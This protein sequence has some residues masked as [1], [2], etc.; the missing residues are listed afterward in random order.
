M[1]PL[2]LT[3]F[4]ADPTVGQ[5][6]VES[7]EP[8]T[9]EQAAPTVTYEL[10]SDSWLAV[11]VQYDRSSL[12]GGHDHVVTP[13][14]IKGTVTWN[15]DDPSVCKV[16]I[17]FAVDALQVDPPGAR[18]RFDLEGETGD[19]D[20]KSIKKNLSG[21]SQ[22]DAS[23]FPEITYSATKCEGTGDKVKV[24]GNL[25]IH[26]VTHPVTTTMRIDA[27]ASS[28]KA[29]GTFQANHADFGM[30]PYTALLGALRNDELLKFQVNVRGTPAR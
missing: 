21:R 8:T 29:R 2:F 18:A 16:D 28:F 30:K 9:E 13:S 24:T 26:G 20:R 17:R 6:A 23:S 25:G 3:A 4:A 14:N 15:A 22:L 12:A 5:S 10:A 7:A 19:G 1:L 27:D 11:L